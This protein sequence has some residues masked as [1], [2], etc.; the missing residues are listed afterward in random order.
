MDHS[1]GVRTLLSMASEQG[2]FTLVCGLLEYASTCDLLDLQNSN[3]NFADIEG[4][5][6]ISYAVGNGH[7]EISKLLLQHGAKA[8]LP[9]KYGRTPLTWAAGGG[10]IPTVQ[11]L[12]SPPYNANANSQDSL[13]QT[14]FIWACANGH[15]Q[16]VAM[17][18]ARENIF[19]AYPTDN[20][21]NSPLTIAAANGRESVIRILL[22]YEKVI[23][24][25]VLT[26]WKEEIARDT[27]KANNPGAWNFRA[28]IAW[29]STVSCLPQNKAMAFGHWGTARLLRLHWERLD[30]G[31]YPI[32]DNVK[33]KLMETMNNN[34][35]FNTH[36][37]SASA[38]DAN[39]LA[40]G[41]VE[42]PDY[43]GSGAT[44]N[45]GLFT[46]GYD[47]SCN[48]SY[49][50]PYEQATGAVGKPAYDES[51][52]PNNSDLYMYTHECGPSDY[53]SYHYPYEQATPIECVLSVYDNEYFSESTY[54]TSEGPADQE[55]IYKSNHNN[56]NN[57][58]I[59]NKWT[60]QQVAPNIH[61]KK[62][63]KRYRK[64]K[65]TRT[66]TN[67]ANGEEGHVA[68]R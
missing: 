30:M 57:N 33:E 46:H 12:L 20:N 47:P 60:Q 14:P 39:E 40:A 68:G 29:D 58:N 13:G 42:L 1:N 11:L 49:Y 21:E 25:W 54:S 17:M 5:S 10:H 9:D 22:T 3:V 45:S 36:G 66:K 8:D 44:N 65:T 64:P 38:N 43:N 37:F 41:E 52:N 18:L 27:W 28:T 26:S 56:N 63:R 62:I 15:S 55:V 34:P 59:N 2:N 32:A 23:Q 24:D 19:P 67:V 50:Y 7:T 53:D 61:N 48:D 51:E 4:R 35:D 16:L 6:P 31:K